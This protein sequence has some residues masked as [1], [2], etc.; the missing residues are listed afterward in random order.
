MDDTRGSGGAGG[1]RARQGRADSGSGVRWEQDVLSHGASGDRTRVVTDEGIEF[2]VVALGIEGVLGEADADLMLIQEIDAKEGREGDSWDDKERRGGFEGTQ[3]HFK[4]DAA[5]DMEVVLVTPR[6]VPSWGVQGAYVRERRMKSADIRER[7]APVSMMAAQR[8]AS[9]TAHARV[10]VA[11]SRVL[12]RRAARVRWQVECWRASRSGVRAGAG[13]AGSDRAEEAA[14]KPSGARKIV[15]EIVT[16]AVSIN[17]DVFKRVGGRDQAGDVLEADEATRRAR[18]VAGVAGNVL[19][20]VG[21][22]GSDDIMLAQVEKLRVGAAGDGGDSLV[23][24]A[25]GRGCSWCMEGVDREVEGLEGKLNSLK[26][27]P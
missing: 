4:G 6:M 12:R 9:I 25:F 27:G 26:E 11:G 2:I 14:V 8:S 24:V 16:T 23:E 20:Q 21:K 19:R 13:S 7:S 15:A 10:G 22:E 18:L 1:G 3:V 5:Q 17:F